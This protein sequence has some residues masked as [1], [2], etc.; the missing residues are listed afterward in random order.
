MGDRLDP[1]EITRLLK[2][3]PTTAYRKGEPYFVGKQAGTLVGKTGMWLFST[4]RGIDSTD[5]YDHLNVIVA[6]LALDHF[7]ELLKEASNPRPRSSPIKVA[8]IPQ[9]LLRGRLKS[10]HALLEQKSLEASISCFWHGTA[11][12]APPA[13]PRLFSSLLKLVP[14]AIETDFDADDEGP[15]RASDMRVPA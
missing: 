13:I 12:A 14:I 1:G 9:F 15:T 2:I 4:N 3:V 8:P 11:R 10:L 7:E 5:F 6:L